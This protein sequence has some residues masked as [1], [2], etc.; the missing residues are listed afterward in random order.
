MSEETVT[1][2]EFLKGFNGME[3]MVARHTGTRYGV[4]A[5]NKGLVLAVTPKIEVTGEMIGIIVRVRAE[6]LE[7]WANLEDALNVFGFPEL[8]T[9]SETHSSMDVVVWLSR[10]GVGMYDIGKI[11]A[12]EKI[13]EK[14]MDAIYDRAEK[15][16]VVGL[17]DKE[18]AVEYMK[19]VF[20]DNLPSEPVKNFGPED[21]IVCMGKEAAYK[22]YMALKEKYTVKPQPPEASK[23][24]TG[25]IIEA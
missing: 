19:N 11:I 18:L 3:T 5:K 15:A 2:L 12:D 16:S 9:K 4:L 25:G 24:D 7:D 6:R 10:P 21:R 14:V 20:S 17:T 22:Q 8:V 23:G 13:V 1:G